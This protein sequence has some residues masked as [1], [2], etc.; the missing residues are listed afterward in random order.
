LDPSPSCWAFIF[1]L[2]LAFIGVIIC[3]SI[4][5]SIGSVENVDEN[6]VGKASITLVQKAKNEIT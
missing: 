1:I 4:F 6:H 3:G 2:S 5:G